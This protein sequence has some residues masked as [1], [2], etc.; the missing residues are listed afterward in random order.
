VKSTTIFSFFIFHF[1]L[2]SLSGIAQTAT[3]GCSRVT[4]SNIPSYP[5]VYFAN[6]FVANCSGTTTSCE[7]GG[8]NPCC[9]VLYSGDP[10]TP[11]FWL[12]KQ[13]DAGWNTVAGPQ[14]NTVFNNV[15]RGTYR[16]RCQVPA[17]AENACKTDAQGNVIRAR[18]CVFNSLGQFLG[19]WGTWDNSPFGSPSPTYTN[20]VVVGATTANDISYTFIDIPETGPELAY[21]LGEVAKI[22]TSA[23][24]DYDLWW[25]AIIEDG[26][27]YKRYKTNGWTNGR[28]PGDE[29]NLTNFWNQTTGW[30]FELYH[31][32]TVQ[33]VTEN[34]LCRNGIEQTPPNTW[35]VLERTIFI[36]PMNTGCRLGVDRQ[37][38]VVS[39]NPAT[40]SITFQNFEPDLGRDYQ[41]NF[42]DLT[43]RVVKS[44]SLTSTNVDISDLQNGIFIISI[45]REG[46]QIYSSKLII[47]P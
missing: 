27:I 29:I 3:G 20:T 9:K 12:E 7:G 11:R 26:A 43:G 5:L 13:T 18:I 35:N 31:S 44:Q 10:V 38:I 4:V 28:V 16:V 1:S 6:A 33:F 25:L 22:N 47:N 45:R 41:I 46:E 40:S 42:V 17:I 30:N 34:S 39:P 14:F 15:A 8:E 36:C 21:D 37:K 24:K 19:F 2:L 23:C 32:Y